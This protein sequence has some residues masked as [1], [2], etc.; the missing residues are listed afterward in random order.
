ML[1]IYQQRKYHVYFNAIMTVNKHSF[2]L[3]KIKRIEMK[4]I[5]DGKEC[6]FSL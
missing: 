5:L 1:L 2:N 3:R 6:R 4:Y